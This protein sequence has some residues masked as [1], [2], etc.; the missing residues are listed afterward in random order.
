MVNEVS[1]SLHTL[2]G[3][4]STIRLAEI[5]SQLDSFDVDPIAWEMALGQP[6]LKGSGC[7]THF[8]IQPADTII[9]DDIDDRQGERN[10]TRLERRLIGFT[11]TMVADASVPI[12]ARFRDHRTEGPPTELIGESAFFTPQEFKEVDH[13]F[14]GRF[15]EYG[16]F[17]GKVG[18]YQMKEEEYVL[19]WRESDGTRT[20][21]GAFNLAFAYMQGV[22]RD[23]LVPPEEHIRLARKLDRIGGL[24]IYRD[25]IRVQPYGDSDFDWL[26]IERNR[27][28]GAAY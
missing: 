25:G 14:S 3:K 22:A 26:D 4:T 9:Q 28:L 10:A 16:Q 21:C 24:Y 23:S 2:R 8:Y 6:S 13:H 7:G 5:Q 27:T 18:I 19:S 1:K 11:N 17:R 20:Q 15:D 12:V